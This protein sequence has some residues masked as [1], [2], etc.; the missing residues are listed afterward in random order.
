MRLLNLLLSVSVS[1]SVSPFNFVVN[2]SLEI[3]F[4]LSEL[5]ILVNLKQ[6]ASPRGVQPR[7]GPPGHDSKKQLI[8]AE[9]KRKP[10]SGS[11]GILS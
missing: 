6:L 11:K 8:F 10:S 9:A 1:T 4:R 7:F 2:I 3:H 5:K